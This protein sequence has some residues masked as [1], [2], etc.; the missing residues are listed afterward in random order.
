MPLTNIMK[1][2]TKFD[3]SETTNK[4]FSKLKQI[5]VIVSLLIQF[6][7]TRETVLKTDVS[8][9]CIGVTLFQYFDGIIRPCAYYYKTSAP[10]E[11]DYKI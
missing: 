5:F 6:D 3:W 7:N 10:A 4:V 8:T 2:N 9:W 11:F 1:Q